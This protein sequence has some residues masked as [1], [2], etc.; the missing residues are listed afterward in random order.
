MKVKFLSWMLLGMFAF[1]TSCSD[2][3]EPTVEVVEFE[4]GEIP[5]LGNTEGELTGTPFTLPNGVTLIEDITGKGSQSGYWNFSRTASFTN[6][7]GTI[8]SRSLSPPV[9]R[10]ATEN[11]YFGS[12]YGYVDLLIPMHNSLNQSVTVTFPAALIL[13]N[14]AGDCQNGVLLKKVVVTIPAGSDYYLNLAF[15]CGNADKSSAG[16][17]DV[18][19]LGVVSNAKPLLDLCDK[20]KNKKINI[21]EFNPASSDDYYIY[22]SQINDLQDIV[23]EVTDGNGLSES[24]IAYIN[25]LPNSQ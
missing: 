17:S 6:K 14:D 20:V 21:E 15:Y 9:S 18:Y 7:D 10:S 11:H 12:G 24:Q 1:F 23:W 2:D 13:R 5:G 22:K 19:S 3:D 25:A 16:S 4:V 8:V